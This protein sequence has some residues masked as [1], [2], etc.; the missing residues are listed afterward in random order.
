MRTNRIVRRGQLKLKASLSEKA[1]QTGVQVGMQIMR[2][3]ILT[4]AFKLKYEA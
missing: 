3:S 4:A 1:Y 2:Q